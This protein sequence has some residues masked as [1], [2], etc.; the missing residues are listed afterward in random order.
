MRPFPVA[1]V[2]RAHHWGMRP[3]SPSF[4]HD[5]QPRVRSTIRFVRRECEMKLLFALMLVA[6]LSLY[7]RCQAPSASGSAA[8]P[9]KPKVSPLAEYAGTWTGTFDGKV[10]MIL[11]LELHGDLLTGSL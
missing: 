11:R 6:T 7:A 10:W 8:P 1:F 3:R 4:C 2:C 9:Q 5:N